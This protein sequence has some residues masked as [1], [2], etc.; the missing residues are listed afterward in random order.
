MSRLP[1][2]LMVSIVISNLLLVRVVYLKGSTAEGQRRQILPSLSSPTRPGMTNGW[3]APGDRVFTKHRASLRFEKW[4]RY[5]A[6]T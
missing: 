5:L 6:T 1:F 2:C 3:C 4:R